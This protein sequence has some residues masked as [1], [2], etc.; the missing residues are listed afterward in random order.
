MTEPDEVAEA[1]RRQIR[2]H[3]RVFGVF[4]ALIVFALVFWWRDLF[5]ETPLSRFMLLVLVV[6]LG[7]YLLWHRLTTSPGR[8]SARDREDGRREEWWY[9]W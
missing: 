7:G 6:I 9:W 8:F 4:M 3:R 5:G 2:Q 1:Q